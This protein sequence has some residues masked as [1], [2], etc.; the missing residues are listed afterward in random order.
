MKFDHAQLLPG[1]DAVNALTSRDR[2]IVKR[3]TTYLARKRQNVF[4]EMEEL[5]KFFLSPIDMEG[6]NRRLSLECV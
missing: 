2:V 3:M 4:A 6:I 1:L 5:E